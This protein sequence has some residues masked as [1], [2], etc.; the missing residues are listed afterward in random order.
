[1]GVHMDTMDTIIDCDARSLRDGRRGRGRF[2]WDTPHTLWSKWDVSPPFGRWVESEAFL[3]RDPT[4]LRGPHS[5]W[6][7]LLGRHRPMQ[8][9]QPRVPGHMSRFS[10]NTLFP[11]LRRHDAIQWIDFAQNTTIRRNIKRDERLLNRPLNRKK[12]LLLSGIRWFSSLKTCGF[13]GTTDWTE[14]CC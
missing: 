2:G 6:V 14:V 7:E 9:Q 1:M 10:H 13:K 8:Q 3:W 5:P 12:K 11:G 4:P